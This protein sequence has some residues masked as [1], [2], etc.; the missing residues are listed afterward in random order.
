MTTTN[1]GALPKKLP[2]TYEG[3]VAL[4]VPRPI[5]DEV[6][7]QNTVQVVD[8][9]AGMKLNSDQEDFLEIL[10]QQI[11]AY[12]AEHLQMPKQKTGLELVRLLLE[13]NE[14]SGDD[15]AELLE[16][17]RSVAYKILKGTRNL[18]VDHVRR[19]AERFAISADAILGRKAG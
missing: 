18:T 14:L 11:E 3:L 4:H 19:L 7:Y 17:D 8:A 1:P 6:S 5:H 12:E 16:V 13:E 10:S 15:L 9:L 2:K